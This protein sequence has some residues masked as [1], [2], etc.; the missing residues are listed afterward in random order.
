MVA[1]VVNIQIGGGIIVYTLEEACREYLKMIEEEESYRAK[2][3]FAIKLPNNEFKYIT[4]RDEDTETVAYGDFDGLPSFLEYA[5]E[6]KLK[7]E[8]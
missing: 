7:G 8:L 3:Y 1:K 6:L 2:I 4:I 5:Q